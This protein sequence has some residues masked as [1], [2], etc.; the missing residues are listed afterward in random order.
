MQAS[1]LCLSLSFTHKQS[2]KLARET[3][4]SKTQNVGMIIPLNPVQPFNAVVYN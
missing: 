1:L 3:K 4:T 2:I